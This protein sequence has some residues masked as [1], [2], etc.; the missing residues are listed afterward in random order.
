MCTCIFVHAFVNL[1][2]FC[3]SLDLHVGMSI[4]LM[5][6]I[7]QY[8]DLVEVRSSL[9]LTNCGSSV[10]W[11]HICNSLTLGVTGSQKGPYIPCTHV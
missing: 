4:L 3:I 8:L 1:T 5:L 6:F 7:K 11:I 10:D 2:G 9:Q